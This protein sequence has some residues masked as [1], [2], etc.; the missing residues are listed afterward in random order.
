[1][2]TLTANDVR[3]ILRGL[4]SIE[5]L[6]NVLRSAADL[7]TCKS[8][9]DAAGAVSTIRDTLLRVALV[10]VAVEHT[11]LRKFVPGEPESQSRNVL[12][13][14]EDAPARRAA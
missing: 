6:T 7:P 1:M 4:D 11:I 12:A 8:I 3:R 13:A 14:N 10:D 5:T 9:Y 2:Q